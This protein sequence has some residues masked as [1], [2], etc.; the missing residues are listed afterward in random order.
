MTLEQII[1]GCRKGDTEA[2]R[3]LYVTYGG[4]MFGVVKRYVSDPATAE[5]LL[6]DG[7]VTLYTHIGEYRGEGSFEGWCRRIFVNTVMSHFR[8][9]NPLKGADDVVTL[10]FHGA[11]APTAIEELS[12]GEI[13][14]CIERL[15]E[16]YRAVFNLHAVEEYG[17]PEIAETLGISE[18]TARSQYLRARMKLIEIMEKRLLA[19]GLAQRKTGGERGGRLSLRPTL[20][21]MEKDRYNAKEKGKDD[22]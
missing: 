4:S 2:R 9:K 13:K 15:P 19:G 14:E 7:F 8:H 16:G 12:A 21:P 6:H 17:Y 22:K 3:E 11:V 1:E 18:A 5:D 20:S 10:N